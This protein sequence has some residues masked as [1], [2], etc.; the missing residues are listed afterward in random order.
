MRPSSVEVFQR[1]DTVIVVYVFPL[2]AE[3]TKK[4]GKLVFYAQIGRIVVDETFDLA[5]MDFQGKLEL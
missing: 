4:D 1:P 3:I 2:S 5:G